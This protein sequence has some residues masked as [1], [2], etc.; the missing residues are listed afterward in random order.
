MVSRKVLTFSIRGL[1]VER[2]VGSKTVLWNKLIKEVRL[3]RVAGPFANI[4]FDSCIQSPIGLVPKTGSDETRLTFHLSYTF[5]GQPVE[6]SLNQWTPKEK[7]KVKYKDLDHAIKAYLKLKKLGVSLGQDLIFLGK[8]DVQS[9]FRLLPLDAHCW[10]W[11]IM[12]AED[13]NTGKLMFFVDKCL[14]FGASISCALFQSFSDAL[15]YLIEFK[16]KLIRGTVTHYLM[17]SFS[18]LFSWKDAMK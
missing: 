14:P 10:A 13:P 4:P 9:T 6:G 1:D 18:W 16:E 3:G 11:L 15:C 2:A 7:C 12:A 8:T 17:I 5:K